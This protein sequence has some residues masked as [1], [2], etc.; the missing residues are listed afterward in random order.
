MEYV[1]CFYDE[2]KII[3]RYVQSVYDSEKKAQK[4]IDYYTNQHGR[5]E[6]NKLFITTYDNFLKRR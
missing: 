6:T 3:H 2:Y 4:E 5:N 1:I